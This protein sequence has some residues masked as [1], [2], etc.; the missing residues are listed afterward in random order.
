MP[1]IHSSQF[2]EHLQEL[3]Q[4]SDQ[5][6]SELVLVLNIRCPLRKTGADGLLDPENGREVGPAVLVDRGLRLTPGPREGLGDD[7]EH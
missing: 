7:V 1:Q 2:G 4:K 3:L 6:L 5:L